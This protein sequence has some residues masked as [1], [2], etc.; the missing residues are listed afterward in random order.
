MA[1]PRQHANL[2]EVILTE[3]KAIFVGILNSLHAA[4]KCKP[5]AD[6]QFWARI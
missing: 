4:E 6:I 5:N 3:Y 1:L 2:Q